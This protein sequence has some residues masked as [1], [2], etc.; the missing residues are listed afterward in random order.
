LLVPT[1]HLGATVVS[2]ATHPRLFAID[3]FADVDETSHI[4]ALAS[5][6]VLNDF[7]YAALSACTRIPSLPICREPTTTR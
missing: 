1:T 4:V 2:L 7:F 5:D 6:R 3:D